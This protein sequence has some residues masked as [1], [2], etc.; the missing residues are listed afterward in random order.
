MHCFGVFACQAHIF[1]RLHFDSRW[2]A[3]IS[4]SRLA[5]PRCWL[6]FRLSS[7]QYYII[8]ELWPDRPRISLVFWAGLIQKL[9]ISEI[10]LASTSLILMQ[11][12]FGN[13]SFW[14]SGWSGPDVHRCSLFSFWNTIISR[15]WLPN[16][17]FPL[18][19]NYILIQNII[20]SEL[21]LARSRLSMNCMTLYLR[22]MILDLWLARRWFSLIFYQMH[23]QEFITLDLWLAKL[24][25]SFVFHQSLY[26]SWN[27][28]ALE[29]NASFSLI[30]SLMLIQNSL[31]QS[32]DWPGPDVHWFS[33]KL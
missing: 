6:I 17:R 29:D 9:I 33:V 23:I 18:I 32:S 5:R 4:E 7:H 12:L 10:W 30:S 22:L 16:L 8:S 19:V 25:Y 13:S 2:E 14:S 24:G 1:F 31:F 15:L 11:I 3:N 28:V 27:N 20:L 21:L 26:K